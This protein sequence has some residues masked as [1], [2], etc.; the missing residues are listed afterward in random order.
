[1]PAIPPVLLKRLY[2]KGSL[3]AQ[4]DGFSLDLKNI[5]APGTI[6]GFKGLELNGVPLPPEQVTVVQP[7]DRPRAATEIS[8][9]QPLQ[10]PLGATFTLRVKGTP[11]GAGD[12]RL[13]VHVVVQDVG[14]LEIP[15][16]DRVE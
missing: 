12:H 10:F 2:V 8:A 4:G 11:L 16:A 6:L 13:K 14:P 5:I 3:R 7:D 15:V 1:M 9:D